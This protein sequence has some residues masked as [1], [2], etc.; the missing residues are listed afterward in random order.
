[1][2]SHSRSVPLVW[3]FGRT[4]QGVRP[5]TQGPPGAVWFWFVMEAYSL[6]WTG[7]LGP[8]EPENERQ[9]EGENL[10]FD[11][12]EFNGDFVNIHFE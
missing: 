1:M 2:S 8:S 12:G 10:I 7:S 9:R 5:S 4:T 3:K 11:A 6:F